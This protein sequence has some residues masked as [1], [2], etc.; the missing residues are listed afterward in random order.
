MLAGTGGV[1][2]HEVLD[3]HQDVVSPLSQRRHLDGEHVEAI[4]EVLAKA[5]IGHSGGQVTVGRRDHSNVDFDRLCSPDSLELSLLQDSQERDLCVGRK[6]THFI[7]KDRAAM[8]LFEAAEPPLRRSGE[9]AF[10]VAKQLR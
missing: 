6:F 7:E 10:L 1:P 8:S 2:S 5:S 9:G 3:E 4:K